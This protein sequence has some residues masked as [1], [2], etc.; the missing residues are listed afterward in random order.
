MQGNF[1]WYS[2]L[3]LNRKFAKFNCNRLSSYIYKTLFL[4]ERVGVDF[5]G[6]NSALIIKI[7]I[8]D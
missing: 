3:K 6:P 7:I 2:I 5:N 4:W 8:E 1:K